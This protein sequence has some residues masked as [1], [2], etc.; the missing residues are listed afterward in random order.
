M[1]TISPQA[2]IVSLAGICLF[3]VQETIH[4][5]FES[6]CFLFALCPRQQEVS[7]LIIQW[8]M[9]FFFLFETRAPFVTQADLKLMILV[10]QPPKCYRQVPPPSVNQFSLISPNY[11]QLDVPAQVSLLTQPP[12]SSS[13]Q[14]DISIICDTLLLHIILPLPSSV[15]PHLPLHLYFVF[16]NSKPYSY[17]LCFLLFLCLHF[18]YFSILPL[19]QHL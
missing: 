17:L 8:Q 18:L 13:E 5:V 19:T 11:T 14:V 2:A 12:G 3:S 1:T 16:S 10:T 9:L 6:N 7:R 4:S 15:L